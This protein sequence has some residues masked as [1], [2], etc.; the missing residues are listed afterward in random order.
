MATAWGAVQNVG[1]H[2]DA[3]FGEDASEIFAMLTTS[4][5]LLR[6]ET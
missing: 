2:E 5:L 1:G 4:S 6:G 3:V